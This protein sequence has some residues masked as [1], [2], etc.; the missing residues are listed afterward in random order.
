MNNETCGKCPANCQPLPPFVLPSVFF[1]F[2]PA[3]CQLPTA[4]SLPLRI[5][6]FHYLYPPMRLE[7]NLPEL[8]EFLSTPRN[9]A[10]VAHTRP[11]GDAIGSCLALKFFL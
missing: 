6:H 10:L 7:K 8:F 9:I 1:I 4:N 11:D 5:P 2:H 3:N